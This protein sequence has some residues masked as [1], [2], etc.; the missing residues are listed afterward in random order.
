MDIVENITGWAGWVLLTCI[1][2]ITLSSVRLCPRMAAS[3]IE[4][5]GASARVAFSF[6]MGFPDISI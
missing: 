3:D 1:A 6:A 2:F 5:F 4:R